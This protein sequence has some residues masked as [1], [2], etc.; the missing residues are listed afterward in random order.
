MLRKTL[1]A[2]RLQE[3]VKRRIHRLQE[4][5]DDGVKIGVPR[6]QPQTPDRTGCNWTMRN[7]GNAAGFEAS[8]AGVLAQVQAEYNL[9]A[10]EG[11]ESEAARAPAE[12]PFGGAHARAKVDPFGDPS[13]DRS[14][15]QGPAP[16]ANP[17]AGAQPAGSSK[18][19]A[20]PFGGPSSP[21]DSASEP[22]PKRPANPF[23]G[24]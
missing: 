4:V 16:T 6:P 14:G 12:D 3:E 1:N 20:D 22:P 10:Q 24:D 8:I 23:G 2:S 7:F 15:N 5:V 11:E 9:A 18:A 19:G 17:F 21:D 13:G